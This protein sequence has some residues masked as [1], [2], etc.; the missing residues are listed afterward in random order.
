MYPLI[1]T[2]YIPYGIYAV[3]RP[4][5]GLLQQAGRLHCHQTKPGTEEAWI[6]NLEA[7]DHPE[8]TQ[9]C[10]ICQIQD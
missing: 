7:I 4:D 2:I 3:G 1:H 10:Q 5:G 6:T 9:I 8:I